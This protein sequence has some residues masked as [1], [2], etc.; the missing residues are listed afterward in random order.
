M[1]ELISIIIQIYNSENNIDRCI[2]SVINQTYKNIEII[3]IDDGSQDSSLKKCYEYSKIDSR[4]RIIHKENEGVAI[5]RN[6]GI[7]SST[8]EF[9]TFVDSD[10][11]LDKSAIENLYNDLKEKNV[12]IVRG[13]YAIDNE[14]NTYDYGKLYGFENCLLKNDNN[15]KRK[16]L[17]KEILNGKFLAYVWLLLIKKSILTENKLYFKEKVTMMEDTI[18]YIELIKLNYNIYI[19]NKINYHYYDN[20][21]SVTKSKNN[22]LKNIESIINVNSILFK[23]L[24]DNEY[25]MIMNTNQCNM[26]INL[27]YKLYKINYKDKNFLIKELN[28]LIDNE[29]FQKMINNVNFSNIPVHFKFQLLCIK[30]KM[31]KLLLIYFF[32][33]KHITKYKQK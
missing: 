20:L 1:N 3:L 15:Y 31:L 27:I 22:I 24:N 33:R 30:Y 14:R 23:I 12:D 9:I 29:N 18:F 26:I 5:A 17:I 10:D 6:V 7:N 13:N 21:N 11:W 28:K 25:I 19:S 16:Q 8:G 4:I 32:I 2:K